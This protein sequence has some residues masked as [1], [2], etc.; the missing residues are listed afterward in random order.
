MVDKVIGFILEF[1]SMPHM[2]Q[3][4]GAIGLEKEYIISKTGE[5]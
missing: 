5:I 3:N 1:N 4:V 2:L